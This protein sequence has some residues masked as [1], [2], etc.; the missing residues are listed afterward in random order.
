MNR[1]KLV[2]ISVFIRIILGILLLDMS[3]GATNLALM[4]GLS[5]S[6]VT[7]VAIMLGLTGIL[8]LVT[9]IYS[10]SKIRKK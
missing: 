2:L 6:S 3:Q 4:D 9:A 1:E 10:F 5:Q 8:M 7:G